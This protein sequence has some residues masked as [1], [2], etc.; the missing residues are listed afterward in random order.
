[1]PFSHGERDMEYFMA[2][3]AIGSLL[4][5]FI[6]A[7]MT[8]AKLNTLSDQI[9]TFELFTEQLADMLDDDEE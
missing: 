4:G 8:Q 9:E 7:L 2:G 5:A 3:L 6:V 1:M